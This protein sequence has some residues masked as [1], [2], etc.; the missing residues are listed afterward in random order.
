M[1]IFSGA[2]KLI[3]VNQGVTALDVQV[4]IYGLWKQWCITDDNAKYLPALRTIGGDPTVGV[5][6]VAP[7]FFLMNGW[8]IRPYEGNHTLNI[9]GNLFV[10]EPEVYGTNITVPTL[11]TYQV[12]VNMA[13]TSDA[14]L[15]TVVSGSGVTQ[16]DKQEITG[17]VATQLAEDHGDGS[18][19]EPNLSEIIGSLDAITDKVELIKQI[20]SGCWRIDGTQLIFF[21]DDN[22]TELARFNLLDSEG[23]ASAEEVFA[24]VRA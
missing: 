1:V 23:Q 8:K 9:S 21:A 5:K 7:Y 4:D 14:S 10:D 3:I 16:Q 6:A 24:R 13:T 18:W 22:V 2:D 20:V 17:M 11:G 19:A 12:L 15:M